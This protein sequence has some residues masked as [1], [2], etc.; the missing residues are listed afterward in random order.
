[1][2]LFVNRMCHQIYLILCNMLCY[3]QGYKIIFLPL[4]FEPEIFRLQAGAITITPRGQLGKLNTTKASINQQK[5]AFKIS[6]YIYYDLES[7][8]CQNIKKICFVCRRTIFLSSK[9]SFITNYISLYLHTLSSNCCHFLN[10]LIK[11]RVI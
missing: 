11:M 5:I 1:M 7:N 6:I 9:R 10:T 8:V 3:N 4:G 2:S